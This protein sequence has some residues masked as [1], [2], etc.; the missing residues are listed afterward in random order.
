MAEKVKDTRCR[1]WATILYPESA[2]ENWQ[3]V[4]SETFKVPTLISPLHDNDVDPFGTKKKP[5]Y[6]L[7]FA[8]DGNKSEDQI[9][10]IAGAIGAVGLE[11][12]KS[13]RSY[14]R[15][16]CHMDNPEKAQYKA[17]DVV[18]LGGL[19]YFGIC[20]CAADKYACIDA[21]I[22]WCEENECYSYARL[23][24]FA[25]A[26]H[27]DWY[28]VLCDNGTYVVKEYLKSAAWEKGIDKSD[29]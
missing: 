5:H 20:S 27:R 14:A 23:F 19:D 11:K 21:M 17:D 28:R 24:R 26:E 10:V 25:K 13:L 29:K 18:C 9:K 8:F 7:I 12:V 22:D 1:N 6:H 4:L 15:Y 3:L 16:L 2:V